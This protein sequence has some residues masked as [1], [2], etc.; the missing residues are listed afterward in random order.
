M[1][2]LK[3]PTMTFWCKFKLVCKHNNIPMDVLPIETGLL[4]ELSFNGGE[5]LSGCP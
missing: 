2:Q 4:L 3:V 1:K 5:Y